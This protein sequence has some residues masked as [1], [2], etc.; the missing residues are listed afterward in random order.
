MKFVLVALDMVIVNAETLKATHVP[1][2]AGAIWPVAVQWLS[3]ENSDSDQ[4]EHSDAK[5]TISPAAPRIRQL[6]GRQVG[7]RLGEIRES[8]WLN[9]E[10]CHVRFRRK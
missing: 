2:L 3:T 1:A 9:S 7:K 8:L 4:K 5:Q 10:F 6:N